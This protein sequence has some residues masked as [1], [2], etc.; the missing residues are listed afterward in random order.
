MISNNQEIAVLIE[1]IARNL[2][3]AVWILQ[4]AMEDL[5]RLGALISELNR[6]LQ[7]KEET[8]AKEKK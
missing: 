2:Q 5:Q 7:S 1:K 3:S 8:K 6:K 4:N